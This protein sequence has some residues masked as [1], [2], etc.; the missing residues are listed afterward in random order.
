MRRALPESLRWLPLLFWV[1]GIHAQT[2]LV[3]SRPVLD[4]SGT[5]TFALSLHSVS[6]GRPAALQ[7]AFQ[8][9]SSSIAALTVERRSRPGSGWQN[10]ILRRQCQLFQL[11]GGWSQ[12]EHDRRRNHRKVT[13]TLVPAADSANLVIK[14]SLG[15]SREGYFIPVVAKSS[16]QPTPVAAHRIGEA[17]LANDVLG[18]LMTKVYSILSHTRR[19]LGGRR[20][21]RIAAG[22]AAAIAFCWGSGG[23]WAQTSNTPAALTPLDSTTQ[24][25]VAPAGPQILSVSAYAAYYSSS[26]PETGSGTLQ[27]NSANLQPLWVAAEAL[28]S[29]G[30]S[31]PNGPLSP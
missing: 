16:A 8:Y 3:L 22:C 18:V 20:S 29:A 2:C 21:A 30:R 12:C 1:T 27:V 23:L 13:A 10:H 6:G 25:A 7:W 4:S 24:S 17:R 19:L 31:S 14:S 11:L 5:A 15:A 28:F 9:S 26:V